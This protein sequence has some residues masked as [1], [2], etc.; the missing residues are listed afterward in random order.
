MI[1]KWR[2]FNFKSVR[3][4]TTV[5]FAPLT[6]FAGA[7]SSGKST[8]LQSILLIVQT[9][10]SNVLLVAELGGTPAVIHAYHWGD[11]DS[12]N[13]E[14]VFTS[15]PPPSLLVTWSGTR[16]GNFTKMEAIKHD[17]AG[18]R[19]RRDERPL[20]VSARPGLSKDERT[21]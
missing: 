8:I 12:D 21:R 2:L 3:K 6:L 15:A 10:Q 19:C 20:I 14:A 13:L 7:N 16:T 5:S 1:S 9:L 18:A 17:F 4:E 11:P